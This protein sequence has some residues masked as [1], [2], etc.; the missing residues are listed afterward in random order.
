MD[1]L[2]AYS[3]YELVLCMI[4]DEYEQLNI[5]RSSNRVIELEALATVSSDN[6]QGKSLQSLLKEYLDACTK[7][8]DE[9]TKEEKYSISLIQEYAKQLRQDLVRDERAMLDVCQFLFCM[10]V[11]WAHGEY[12]SRLRALLIEAEWITKE[13]PKNRLIFSPFIENLFHSLDAFETMR[14]KREKKYVLLNMD[15][16]SIRLTSFQ[17][18]NAKELI[19]V[20]K[21]LAASDF[22]LIPTDLGDSIEMNLTALDLM[23]HDKVKKIVLRYVF[24]KLQSKTYYKRKSLKFRNSRLEL[25]RYNATGA[26]KSPMF[27]ETSLQQ[28]IESI[29][30]DLY[31][32]LAAEN[33]KPLHTLVYGLEEFKG[34][35][36]G[37]TCGTFI[38]EIMADANIREFIDQVVCEIKEL[39]SKYS[40]QKSSP[41][42]IQDV[43]LY[44]STLGNMFY[45]E[46]FRVALLDASLIDDKSEFFYNLSENH[47]CFG[48]MRKPYKMIQVANAL[49][50]PTIWDE[51]SNEQVDLMNYNCGKDL[52]PP[53]SFYVQ[54]YIN[55]HQVSF[56]LNKVVAVSSLK[57]HVQ[58]ST[59]TIQQKSV[60][61]ESIFD[62]VCDNMWNH[63]MSLQYQRELGLHDYCDTH[64]A[65]EYSRANYQFFKCS[66]RR[67][68]NELL[69]R[70]DVHCAQDIDVHHAVPISHQCNCIFPLS[71]RAL[72]DI[73]LQPVRSHIATIIASALSSDSFFGLYSVS[74][75]I[76]IDDSEQKIVQGENSIFRK[77]M[78]NCLEAHQKRPTVFYDK[79]TLM[80]CGFMGSWCIGLQ[81]ILGKGPYVQVSSTDYVLKFSS[82]GVTDQDE[83]FGVYNYHANSYKE[84]DSMRGPNEFVVLKKGQTLDSNGSIKA[85]YQKDWR[86]YWMRLELCILKKHKD[87]EYSRCVWSRNIRY[88]NLS[89]PTTI[90]ITPQH[91]LSSI[92]FEVSYVKEFGNTFLEIE[93]SSI[94][95]KLVLR[96]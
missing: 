39:F 12:Q 74:L 14:L 77:I 55:D 67:M 18:Q 44:S 24:G 31:E 19:A 87:K 1:D 36:K 80:A 47:I 10:P 29:I 33:S 94:Q 3:K 6:A 53:N 96:R 17:M 95:E 13:D 93:S 79:S 92:E 82:N 65:G 83:K 8:H 51:E 35:L 62:S 7:E 56:L 41:D 42:G 21:K 5:Q 60:K 28:I 76:I 30:S 34:V 43:I 88:A 32:I 54:A 70:K 48:A 78:Q 59:F 90:R 72:V 57:G 63:I 84:D 2:L 46:L 40:T 73:G 68:T 75:L 50:P 4:F 86:L 37:L 38:D 71:Y 61:L 81:Q 20:S 58:K 66:I 22:L 16:K 11:G 91:H 49:S 89:H 27:Q 26:R 45:R 64:L 15:I 25:T 69:Q 9:Q 23:V 85:F 52:L